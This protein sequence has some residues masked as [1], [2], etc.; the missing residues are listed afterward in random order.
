MEI[1]RPERHGGDL[2]IES[3][4]DLE[5]KFAAGDLHPLDL[6]Q[7]AAFYINDMLEPVRIKLKKNAKAQKL[8]KE[9]K[10]AK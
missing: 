5:K 3:Y 6:K 2:N 9:I 10:E 7:S 4:D 8:A 1:K